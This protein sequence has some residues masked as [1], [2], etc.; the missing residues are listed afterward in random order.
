MGYLASAEPGVQPPTDAD[1]AGFTDPQQAEEF[2]ARTGVDFLTISIGTVHGVYAG[3]PKLDYDRLKEIKK[4]VKV[5]LI[6]HGGSGTPCEMMQKAISL[7]I[8]RINIYTEYG[9]AA[10]RALRG[11]VA[12]NPDT[13]AIPAA[14]DS[15]MDAVEEAVKARINCFTVAMKK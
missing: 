4:R 11:F 2:V 1:E 8:A 6:L 7:G 3:T 9:L 5:P 12:E 10:D 13:P 14:L 15:A